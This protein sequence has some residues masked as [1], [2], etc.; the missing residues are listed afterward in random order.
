D[1]AFGELNKAIELDPKRVESYL[2]MAKFHLAAKEP[3][4]AEELYKRAISVNANSPLVHTEYGKFLTQNN[5]PAEAEAELRKAVE[6]GPKDRTARFVL[7]SYY[8]VNK[9]L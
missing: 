5:R 1:Q 7:A 3:Q 6:V 2:S 9:Q 4:Q 8:L